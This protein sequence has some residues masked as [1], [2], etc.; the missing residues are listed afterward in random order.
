MD[1]SVHCTNVEDEKSLGTT[2]EKLA[3]ARAEVA[4]P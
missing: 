4:E 2:L 1:R 3:Q